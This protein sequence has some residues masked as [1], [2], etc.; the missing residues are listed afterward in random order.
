M[1]LTGVLIENVGHVGLFR[2][3]SVWAPE[4]STAVAAGGTTP[5]VVG[6]VGPLEPPPPQLDVAT[7]SVTSMVAIRS[8]DVICVYLT[9]SDSSSR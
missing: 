5:V 7:D 2:T 1:T 9:A 3:V 8:T 6:D 4:M